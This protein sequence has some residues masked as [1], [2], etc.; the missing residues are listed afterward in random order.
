M[1]PHVI[2]A[3]DEIFVW[4][5]PPLILYRIYESLPVANTSGRIGRENDVA[6]LCVNGRVPAGGPSVVPSI[7]R[8]TMHKK[9][10]RIRL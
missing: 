1:V 5:T 9:G 3:I 10:E 8:A 4:Q 6:L 7:L 2:E